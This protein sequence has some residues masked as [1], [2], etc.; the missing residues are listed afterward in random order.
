MKHGVLH[1]VDL[2][3]RFIGPWWMFRYPDEI[4]KKHY[5]GV[6]QIFARMSLSYLRRKTL[7]F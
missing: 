4:V 3:S 2:K 7:G 5:L 1:H 6:V